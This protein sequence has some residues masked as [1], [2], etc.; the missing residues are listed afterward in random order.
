[1]MCNNPKLDLV[2]I[3]AHIKF[4]EI[5]SICSQDIERKRNYDRQPK[6]KIAPTFSKRGY[7]NSIS[8]GRMYKD[9]V[10]CLVQDFW[11]T[12]VFPYL[13][14]KGVL[15]FAKSGGHTKSIQFLAVK[16]NAV[17]SL[18][19]EATVH[20]LLSFYFSLISMVWAR[21]GV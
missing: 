2:N 3:N 4:C 12:L 13:N 17:S 19:Q 7:K 5:L 20:F 14:F 8:F 11:G 16:L 9:T 10:L 18:F 1:M 6:S 15:N 21:E